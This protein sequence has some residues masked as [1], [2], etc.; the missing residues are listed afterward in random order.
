MPR[1]LADRPTWARAAPDLP[2]A[3]ACD[4][5][6]APARP[7]DRRSARRRLGR[8][9]D[10][11]GVPALRGPAGARSSPSSAA[12]PAARAARHPAL[13]PAR[14]G[15]PRRDGLF[16]G[17][18]GFQFVATL[19]LQTL[20]AGGDPDRTGVPAGRAVRGH[21]RPADGHRDHRYGTAKPIVAG[22]VSFALGYALFLRVDATRT[23]S[24][25][26]RRSC[27]SASGSPS[28]TRP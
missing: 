9:R 5:R 17:Y 22:R 2:G 28:A 3:R 18:V 20:W 19:Y 12:R 26:C 1:Y 6:H 15:Q 10:R 24:R 13:R 11:R 27:C 7:H 14:A 25:S 4:R 8:A 23:C 21:R 16:G